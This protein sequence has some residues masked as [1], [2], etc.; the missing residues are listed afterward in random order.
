MQNTPT[1]PSLGRMPQRPHGVNV[2]V[3]DMMVDYYLELETVKEIEV[4][5][6][7]CLVGMRW[8]E[9][10]WVVKMPIDLLESGSLGT[11]SMFL[12]R[13]ISRKRFQYL[14]LSFSSHFFLGTKHK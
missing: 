10:E 7:R 5:V 13:G 4:K 2:P 6:V 11:C 9:L 14:C 1:H 8:M 12:R 3:N